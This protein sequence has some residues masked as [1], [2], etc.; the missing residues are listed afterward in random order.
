MEEADVVII[1][2][3]YGGAVPALRLAEASMSVVILERGERKE[4]R[5]LQH[6]DAPLDISAVV[7]LVVTSKNIAFRTGKLA[8]GASIT[9]DGAFFRMPQRSFEVADAAGTPYWPQGY[10][11]AALDPTYETVE[12]MLEVRQFPWDEIP[13]AGGLFAKMLDEV[14]ASCDRARMNYR[15]CL[16]CGFCSVGCIYD[17]K[18]TLLHSYIPAAEAAGAELR[19]GADV[20]TIEPS[21]TG[22]LVRYQ[23]DGEAAEIFG[24]RVFVA[25][26]GIHTPALLLRSAAHLPALSEQVGENFNNNGEHAVIGILP[27]DHADLADYRCYQGMDNGGLM[28]FHWYDEDGFTLHPGAGFEPTVLSGSLAAPDHPVLPGKAWGME[29]KRFVETIY[30]HRLIGFSVLGLADGHAAITVKPDGSADMADR[31]SEAHDAYLDRVE[32]VVA[33][34]GEAAG[35]TLLPA[36][37]RRFAGTTS[38]HLL[39]ACRISEGKKRRADRRHQRCRDAILR[40]RP[41]C[42]R[43]RFRDS[44]TEM[45]ARTSYAARR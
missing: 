19:T 43:T 8:G 29:Y 6:S 37:S 28:S 42:G 23:R 26:G 13:K 10:S 40:S 36:V 14:G 38:A 7:D 21:G 35:I 39:A 33:G 15:D 44:G 11:R 22:Y 9:M 3:G 16:Q 45:S 24:R 34:I 1:G 18:V 12:Q 41:D 20:S 4:A 2:S 30:P 17:K 5:D 32:E 25:C 27:A 31:P